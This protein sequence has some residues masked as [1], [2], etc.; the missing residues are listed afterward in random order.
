[1]P[2]FPTSLVAADFN[3]DGKTDVLVPVTAYSGCPDTSYLFAKGNGDGTF[4]PG[5]PVCTPYL[6]NGYPLAVDLNADGNMDVIIPYAGATD[7]AIGPAILQGNGDGTFQTSP[8]YYAGQAAN[9]ATIADFNGDG[10]PDVV[11]IDDGGFASSFVTEMLNASQPVSV[12]PLTVNYGAVTVATKKAATVILTNDQKKPLAITSITLGGTDPGDFT[13][14]SNCGTSR[15][16]GWDCTIT[17]TFTPTVTGARTA[18]LSILDA[19]GTQTVQL[20]G[21]GK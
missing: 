2:V 10:M 3:K 17:V 20:N 15:K 1:M 4:T 18:T 5:S 9:N 8:L 16:A 21:T 19:V 11:L 12:S 6:G 7:T 14:T 13:E